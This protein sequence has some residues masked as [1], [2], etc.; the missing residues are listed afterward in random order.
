MCGTVYQYTAVTLESVVQ[1]PREV[2]AID[3]MNVF[4]LKAIKMNQEVPS[5]GT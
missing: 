1:I 2:E 5:S 4:R 3:V